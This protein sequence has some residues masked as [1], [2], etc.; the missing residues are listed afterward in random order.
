MPSREILFVIGSGGREHALVWHLRQHYPQ[1]ALYCAPG[2]PGIARLATCLPVSLGDLDGLVAATA[3]LNPR[4][5]IVGPEAPLVAG[6]ADR[7]L[8]RGLPVLGPSAAPGG[9]P[10]GDGLAN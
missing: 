5:T 7:F 9:R 4:L 6:V 8:A 2:N 3:D 10:G 1:A